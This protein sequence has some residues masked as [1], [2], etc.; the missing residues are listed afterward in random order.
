MKTDTAYYLLLFFSFSFLGWLMEIVL[1]FLEFKR[2]INRGFL[3]GPYCPIYGF[4]TVLIVRLLSRYAADPLTL[5]VMSLA[6]CA[7][8][9]YITSVLMEKLFHARWWDYSHRHFNLNGRICAGTLIPFGVMGMLLVYIIKPAFF[10]LFER[11]PAAWIK[12]VCIVLG[13]A[14][15]ADTIVSVHVLG[16]IRRLA[17]S[18][19]AD[20]TETLNRQIRSALSEYGLLLRR[21]LRAFPYASHYN[22]QLRSQWNE[23]RQQ[24]K[25]DAKARIQKMRD[26]IDFYEQKL[27]ADLKMRRRK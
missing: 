24:L 20:D 26:E 19:H 4:G 7:T 27:K 1:K 6:I 22:D 17:S 11:I 18:T 21:T 12:A 16:R 3:I 10:S 14:M 5:F 2:F 9:E 13:G 25:S 15:L 8:L 23:R